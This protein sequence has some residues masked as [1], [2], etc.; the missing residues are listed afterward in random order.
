MSSRLRTQPVEPLGLLVRSSPASSR[1]V[2]RVEAR[3]VVEQACVAAP[4]MTASGVRRSC[5]TELSSALRSRSVSAA[6]RAR[7]ASLGELGALERQ[8]RSGRAKVSSRCELLG[9]VEAARDRPGADAEHAQRRR[10]S[11]SSGR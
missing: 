11:R 9:I 5:E 6:S 2:A 8:R 10:A 7:C 3:A 1:R 4:V